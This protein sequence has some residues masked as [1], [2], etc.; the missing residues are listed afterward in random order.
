MFP[1]LGHGDG[2]A[3]RRTQELS[4]PSENVPVKLGLSSS[5]YSRSETVDSPVTE[6][7]GLHHQPR[8]TE[9]QTP[10]I[11]TYALGGADA[12]SFTIDRSTAQIEHQ[13]GR[14]FRLQRRRTL[15]P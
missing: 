13:G 1:D 3:T 6:A 8:P 7:D 4:G 9:R 5:N 2:W 12:D 11:L 14:G 15:T 10:E